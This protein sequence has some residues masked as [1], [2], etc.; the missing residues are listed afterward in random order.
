VRHALTALLLFAGAAAA[1]PNPP[2]TRTVRGEV[3]AV[4]FVPGSAAMATVHLN[5]LRGDSW[6]LSDLA[7]LTCDGAKV[8]VTGA[9]KWLAGVKTAA[10]GHFIGFPTVELVVRDAS[11]VPV[12]A[13]RFKA[14]VARAAAPAAPASAP[15]VYHE[16]LGAV[17]PGPP[18]VAPV[19]G[20]PARTVYYPPE[21]RTR[22]GYWWVT[23]RM[24]G[25]WWTSQTPRGFI[26][27]RPVRSAFHRLGLFR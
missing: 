8:D 12:E 1:Q 16:V 22:G 25:S 9:V 6:Q 21:L 15:V 19:Y 4:S 27:A 11:Y 17:A 24:G 7:E 20:P 5:N 10:G 13:A 18:V 23:D 26:P 14:P 3:G 2:P